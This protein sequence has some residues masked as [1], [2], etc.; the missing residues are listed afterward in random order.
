MAAVTRGTSG[1]RGRGMPEWGFLTNHGLVLTYVGRH[2]DSTGREIAAAVGITERA[3]RAIVDDLRQAGYVERER[4]GRRNRY[5]I[6]PSRPVRY[7]GARAVTVGAL[8][9][10]LWR[11]EGPAPREAS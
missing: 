7:L 10:L 1:A 9:D 3:V 6:N 5:R 11:D 8:L 4:V 2:P